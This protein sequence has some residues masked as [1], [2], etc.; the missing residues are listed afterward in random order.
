M[1]VPDKSEEVVIH[2]PADGSPKDSKGQ[3]VLKPIKRKET[4]V[5]AVAMVGLTAA[6]ATVLLVTYLLGRTFAGDGDGT[7]QVPWYVLAAGAVVLA[8]PLV[9]AGYFFLRNDEL[10]PYRGPALA[11]RVAICAAVYA[12]LWGL[13][14][15]LGRMLYGETM[16]LPMLLV[17]LPALVVPGAVA[18]VASLDLDGLSAA[19]HC[20]FYVAVTAGLRLLMGLPPL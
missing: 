1:K 5:S 13:H 11:V 14:W 10:E 19:F 3:S 7:S 2:A 16:E 12:G 15:Y 18:S 20:G 8:P 6:V 9:L 17:A 4:K